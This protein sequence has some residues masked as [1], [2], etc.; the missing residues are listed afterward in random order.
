M[1]GRRWKNQEWVPWYRRKDYKGNLTEAEK[2]ELDAFRLQDNHPAT[3]FEDL[4]GE[5]QGYI[6][7]LELQVYDFKQEKALDRPIFASIAG[8]IIIFLTYKGLIFAGSFYYFFGTLLL[9]LPWYFY[10]REWKK[11]ADAF[12]FAPEDPPNLYDEGIQTEWELT[13]ITER[14]LGKREMEPPN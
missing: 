4:P 3:R 2:R 10:S 6:I 9:T 12:R 11:N 1:F 14:K 13:Y 8:A 7:A 5:V